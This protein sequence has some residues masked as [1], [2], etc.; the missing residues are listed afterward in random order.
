[1][2][3]DFKILR[4]VDGYPNRYFFF[5]PGCKCGHGIPTEGNPAWTWNG[6]LDKPT[7]NPS[8]LVRGTKDIPED[9][10]NAWM[11]DHNTPL[12]TPIPTVCHSYVKDGVIEFLSDCT[13]E[14]AG[15]KVPLEKF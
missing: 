14:L 6:S 1:M 4:K 8:I 11:A 10:Y 5:C 7:F 2:D 3:E 13:H 15:K 12:P 9:V